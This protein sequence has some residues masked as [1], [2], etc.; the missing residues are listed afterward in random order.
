MKINQTKESFFTIFVVSC[1]YV[2]RKSSDM[3]GVISECPYIQSLN[4]GWF[5]ML[6]WMIKGD[7]N[8]LFPAYEIDWWSRY[9]ADYR[10]YKTKANSRK[11]VIKIGVILQAVVKNSWP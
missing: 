10:F 5:L 11:T 3:V 1:V 4:L 6:Q 2:V 9:V 8:S 7:E